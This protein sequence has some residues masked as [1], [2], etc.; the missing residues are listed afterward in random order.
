VGSVCTVLIMGDSRTISGRE[1]ENASDED[2][3]VRESPGEFWA[4]LGDSVRTA[5]WITLDDYVLREKQMEAQAK[6]R[7]DM[8]EGLISEAELDHS[9]GSLESG[10]RGKN[11]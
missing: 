10:A 7:R 2:I 1:A 3:V 6:K 5:E 8:L 4:S 9:S 11:E